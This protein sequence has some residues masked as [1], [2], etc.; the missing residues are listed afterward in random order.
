MKLLEYKNKTI[1]ELVNKESQYKAHYKIISN[2]KNKY[3][4]NKLIKNWDIVI[5]N[6]DN[7]IEL[8]KNLGD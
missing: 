2:D 7:T 1:D 4:N 6:S 3:N 5:Q 8:M